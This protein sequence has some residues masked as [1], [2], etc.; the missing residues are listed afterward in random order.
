VLDRAARAALAG[1]LDRLAGQLDRRGVAPGAVTGVGFA[2]GA[3]ACV[4]AG[5]GRWNVALGLWLANRLA[6]GLDGP[7][8]RRRGATELGGFADI[9]ADFA[10]YAGFVLGVAVAVPEARLACVALLVAYYLS[11]TVF[12]AWSSVAERRRRERPDER[13][14]HFVGGLAEGTETVVAY[15]AL[16]LAPGFAAEI[17][18]AFAAMVGVTALQRLWF[19]RGALSHDGPP[20]AQPS[21]GPQ[22]SPDPQSSPGPQSSGNRQSRSAGVPTQTS[23]P[24]AGADST[25]TTASSWPSNP[26]S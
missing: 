26:E 8:A 14:L 3:A 20:P 21:L 6:D 2:L 23:S 5:A 11:G 17:A 18:W 22:S 19:V 1:P 12:L 24:T 4:A 13:S 25:G 16:C 10:V 15:T 7:L 9:V